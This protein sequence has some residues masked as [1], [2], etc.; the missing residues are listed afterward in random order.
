M[1]KGKQFYFDRMVADSY[2]DIYSA[3][4]QSMSMYPL[5]LGR[6]GEASGGIA[7]RSSSYIFDSAIDNPEVGNEE[8]LDR[9]MDVGADVVAPADTIGNPTK[10]T[11]ETVKMF[12]LA[13]ERGFNGNVMVPLQSDHRQSYLEHY[14]TL[15]KRLGVMG[16]DIK[17]EWVAIGGIRDDT[18][19]EQIETCMKIRDH[20]G[21]GVRLH[22][23]GIGSNRSWVV[24]IQNNPSLLDSFDTAAFAQDVCN[25]KMRD[26]TVTTT[27]FNLPRGKNSTAIYTALMEQQVYM[28]NYLMGPHPRDT[29]VPTH[30]QSEEVSNL[31][32]VAMS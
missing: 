18:P 8:V 22:G 9:A 11:N 13:D 27:Q 26:C 28:L 6:Y 17:D 31:I 4:G 16:V 14:D 2:V 23:L 15:K 19:V 5:R 30:P 7:E 21:D 3:S 32:G 24:T 29:D 10:T 12:H 25:G 20:V 1:T